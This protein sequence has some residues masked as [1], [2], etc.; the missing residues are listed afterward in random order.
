MA[1][2]NYWYPSQPQLD[3]QLVSG[4][5]QTYDVDWGGKQ[6]QSFV[7]RLYLLES[8]KGRVDYLDQTVRLRPGRIFILPDERVA[9]YSCSTP[10]K[11]LWIHF[12]LEF[13]PGI[14]LFGGKEP[15][16]SPATKEDRHL[17]KYLLDG[18]DQC[19]GRKMLGK[20]ISLL[21][22]LE[23][24]IP[25]EKQ[26]FSSEAKRFMPFLRMLRDAPREAFDLKKIARKAGMHPTYFSNCFKKVFGVSP[27][28]YHLTQRLLLAQKLLRTSDLTLG[29]I[30][31]KCG[32]NDQFFFARIFK[33]ELGVPP[34][35]FRKQSRRMES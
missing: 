29:E 7:T 30:A 8:G 18:F 10:I 26:E 12:R 23:N 27:S 9:S 19:S 6:V 13:I 32:Y 11:L 21:K 33:R 17:F 1:K 35:M 34:G 16:D 20:Y 2:L 22:L 3:I 4:C 28:K 14:S 25:V 5:D 24:R 15:V 31:D